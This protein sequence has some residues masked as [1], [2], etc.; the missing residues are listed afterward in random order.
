MS[1]DPII[2]KIGKKGEIRP[3]KELR[4]ILGMS[5]GERVKLIM[6]NKQLIMEVIPSSSELLTREKL[7]KTSFD[8]LERESEHQQKV[9]E[10]DNEN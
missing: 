5:A 2:V 7:Y 9:W 1:N 4:K 10:E 3:P 8:E 6:K